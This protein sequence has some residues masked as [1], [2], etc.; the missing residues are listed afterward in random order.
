[1][2]TRRTTLLCLLCALPLSSVVIISGSIIIAGGGGNGPPVD[3]AYQYQ[4]STGLRHRPGWEIAVS[5]PYLLPSGTG[6]RRTIARRSCIE[7]RGGIDC[8]MSQVEHRL[9]ES[10]YYRRSTAKCR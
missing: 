2:R 1:M 9:A 8:W 6:E 10:T 4:G 7:Y 3:Y 5:L